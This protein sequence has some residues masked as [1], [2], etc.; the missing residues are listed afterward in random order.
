MWSK[1]LIVLLPF[2]YLSAFLFQVDKSLTQDLGRHLKL[3]E[4]ITSC[5]CVPTTNLFSFTQPNQPFINHH[6]L[7]EVVFYGLYQLG[8]IEAI[9]V[10]KMFIITAAVGFVYR[11]AVRKGSIFWTT[12][13]SIPAIFIFS[14]RFDARPEIFSFLF[15]GIFLYVLYDFKDNG[16]SKKIWI[17][18]LI[19]LLWVNSHIYFIVG[20]ILT[21]ILVFDQLWEKR[22]KVD[23]KLLLIAFL[24]GLVTLF[25][26]NHIYGALLPL[27]VLNEYGYSIVENQ[28]PLFLNT[29]LPNIRIVYFELMV[30][31]LFLSVLLTI[32]KQ[33]LFTIFSSLFVIILGFQQVRNF[34]LFLLT[35]LPVLSFSLFELEKSFFKRAEISIQHVVKGVLICVVGL[36]YIVTY[37]QHLSSP[38]FGFWYIDMG[39]K[40]VDFLQTNEIK[41]PIFNNF[42]IGSY[43]L[44]RLYPQ[45]RV[46]VD[47]RPEAYSVAF[48]D[49]YKKMQEDQIFFQE[50]T[51][52]YNLNTVFFT[53]GDITP[54]AQTFLQFLIASPDWS[55]VYTDE[56][57]LI[58]V[59]NTKDNEAIIKKYKKTLQVE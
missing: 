2:L 53:H 22:A 28:S 34:P 43:L 29:I 39:K 44:F 55:V 38:L 17:L 13:L 54:W 10:F 3:G 46:F 33:S 14:E 6:W 48:F 27:T 56:Y 36:F 5:W 31:V 45:E 26:P 1:F 40:G 24:T 23:R 9:L 18:P 4:I 25:N 30:L 32:K 49:E 21:G 35:T 16:Y 42:N 37:F 47:G 19:E 11:L 12:L 20:V 52:R 59:R 57:V 15:L 51:K 58:A 41:G 7:S 8:A 50:Q